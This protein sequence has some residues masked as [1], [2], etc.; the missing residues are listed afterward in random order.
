MIQE[1]APVG[2][3]PVLRLPREQRQQEFELAEAPARHPARAMPAQSLLQATPILPNNKFSS[4]SPPKVF[5][6]HFCCV[7]TPSSRLTFRFSA[8]ARGY[9]SILQTYASDDANSICVPRPRRGR[10][11]RWFTAR[12]LLS[13]RDGADDHEWFFAGRNC[14][15]Q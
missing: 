8:A 5:S 13:T 4:D 10:A 1:A 9:I 15:G 12:S 11:I 7:V 6:V 2:V 14:L 3:R